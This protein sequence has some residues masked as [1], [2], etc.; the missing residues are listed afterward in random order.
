[1]SRPTLSESAF[2]IHAVHAGGRRLCSEPGVPSDGASA[3]VV[4]RDPFHAL[5]ALNLITLPVWIFDID[6]RRVY[7]ANAAGLRVWSA[8]SVDEL[9]ARDMGADM[10]ESVARRLAQYQ[11]DFEAN[12]AVF[13]EQ[14]T[15]YPAGQP[16]SLKVR[17]SGYRLDDG[18]MAMLCEGSGPSAETPDSLRSVEALLHTAV[19]ITLYDASGAP[20]YRNPAARE[21]VRHPGETLQQRIGD[22]AKYTRLVARVRRDGSTT[23]TLPVETVRGRRWHEL[24]ARACRDAV[25]GDAAL[26]VSEADVDQLKASEAQASFLALHDPLTGL[27]NRSHVQQHFARA[28]GRLKASGR[29]A[30][31]LVIDLDHFKDVNDTLGHAVGDELLVE[32]ARRLRTAVR[33]EDLVAR[34]GGDEFLILLTARNIHAEV[35]R[36]DERIRRA[37]SAPVLVRGHNIRVTATLGV[38]LFPDHGGDFETL[39][40][41]A[42][43]ALYAAKAGGRDALA[44]YAEGMSHALRARTE[45]EGDLRLAIERRA[46]ELHYQPLVCVRTNRIVGAEALVRWRHPVR[47][48]VPPEEFIP[49]CESTGLICALGRQVIAMAARQVAAWSA[50]GHDLFVS[51][52]MSSREFAADDVVQSLADTI[53]DAG[54]DPRRL[55]IE[56]TESMLLAGDDRPLQT[57]R[58]MTDLGLSVALDDFGTGYSN[59]ATLRRFP[60]QTLKIDRSFIHGLSDNSALAQLIVDLCRLMNLRVV[61]EGVE[62]A[63]QLRWVA[64]QGIAQYQGYLF[65][66][67]MPAGAFTAR[68]ESAA[69]RVPTQASGGCPVLK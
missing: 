20:L 17:F 29:Q 22:A 12:G 30:A 69:D 2:P 31:L 1:M 64:A 8:G 35:V 59:L 48:L 62:T 43:L 13:H 19:M 44:F 49:L 24:S 28:V 50:A 65:A 66:R 45:L 11:S 58:A 16:V 51:V 52:N 53:A 3:V 42:D 18:R 14:W 63:E 55:Q 9:R 10:S 39:L 57:L 56:I 21:A 23:L 7:W 61:A 26:L 40:R 37:V 60:L 33:H 5:T 4:R 25:T 36:V 32:V 27:P 46:F 41:S 47:G 6:R 15:L 34:F 67:P 68:L 38:G 54:C